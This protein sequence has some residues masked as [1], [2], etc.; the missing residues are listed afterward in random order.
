[1]S[2][3][4]PPWLVDS[5]RGALALVSP[6]DCAGCGRADVEL[7]TR[8]RATLASPPP[9]HVTRLPDGTPLRTVL[10]YEGMVRDVVLAFKQQGRLRLARP[11]G[12]AMARA[13]EPWPDA[14]VLPVPGSARG[15]RVRGYEPVEL[16]LKAAGRVPF[17]PGLRILR[18][19]GSQK[20]RS[21]AERAD[22]RRGSMRASPRLAG[23]RVVVVDD[24]TTTGAS[25][26]EAVRA[27]RSAG[28]DVVG[29]ASVAATPLMSEKGV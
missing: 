23:R 2:R 6:C 4:L 14:E 17:R 20:H 12:P 13:L 26:A 5:L 18:A 27:A 28:A 25:L 7:C 24:V 11:L 15:R 8:C 3:S 29:A 21:R 9:A 19:T 22:A 1:M 16:L 10:T